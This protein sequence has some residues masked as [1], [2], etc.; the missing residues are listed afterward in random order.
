MRILITGANGT[1][2]QWVCAHLHEQGQTIIGFGRQPR[3]RAE[4]DVWLQ[5]DVRDRTALTQAVVGCDAVVHLA[6]QPQYAS[7][8]HPKADLLVNALGTLQT[9]RAAV[10][11]GVGRF[12]LLSSSAVYGATAGC[13]HEQS[14]LHPLSPYGVSK[15]SAEAYTTMFQQTAG[16]P[17]VIL[18]VFNVYG[19]SYT[20][21]WRTTVESRFLQAALRGDRPTIV[22]DP[23]RAYDFVHISDVVQAIDLALTADL[24]PGNIFNIGSG[25]PT[26]LRHL[27]QCCLQA[28]GRPHVG[29]CNQPAT[30][31]TPPSHW[32]D[33]SQ[34]RRE[35]G[36]TP[37]WHIDDWI[38]QMAQ[39]DAA[40]T[41]TESSPTK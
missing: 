16:L 21:E 7:F 6:V 34:S 15:A 14:P 39:G 22:G 25:R 3:A 13:L 18:R 41:F 24:H 10:A 38:S 12:V 20:G 27:A 8:E 36:Y 40:Q 35:L 2:G 29:P 33:L 28:V 9:L 17:T 23:E 5:G 11:Q 26:T 1:I 30:A 4:V 19:H 32:A 31:R 37:R